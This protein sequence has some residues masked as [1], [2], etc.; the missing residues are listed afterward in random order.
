MA[1]NAI[2]LG[3]ITGNPRTAEHGTHQLAFSSFSI[4]QIPQQADDGSHYYMGFSPSHSGFARRRIR[5]NL[6]PS[7]ASSLK[8]PPSDKANIP[9]SLQGIDSYAPHPTGT[10][11]RAAGVLKVLSAHMGKSAHHAL[12]GSRTSWAHNADASLYSAEQ[13]DKHAQNGR[14]SRRGERRAHMPDRT[15]VS[16]SHDGKKDH[17]P[18]L[19][20]IQQTVRARDVGWR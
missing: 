3:G 5:E 14:F 1:Y 18:T 6:T 19:Q 17:N 4:P 2:K 9:S 12:K 20:D 10:P 15:L 11:M 8:Y 7:L 13:Q 16:H